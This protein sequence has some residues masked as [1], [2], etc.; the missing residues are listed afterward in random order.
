[1]EFHKRVRVDPNPGELVPAVNDFAAIAEELVTAARGQ[2][3]ELTGPNS[4]LTGPTRQVVQ[5]AL[6]VDKADH[7]G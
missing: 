6:E 2:S 3:I 7:L 4:L 1:M 5:T